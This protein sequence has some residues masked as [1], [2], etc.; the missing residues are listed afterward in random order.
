MQKTVG[1]GVEMTTDD[2]ARKTDVG[3]E[4]AAGEVEEPNLQAPVGAAVCEAVEPPKLTTESP[5]VGEHE[6]KVLDVQA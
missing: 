2:D 4:L 3:T 1:E 6:I 5:G